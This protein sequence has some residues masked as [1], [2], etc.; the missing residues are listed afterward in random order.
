M[1]PLF[2]VGKVNRVVL[3]TL[4]FYFVFHFV[5]GVVPAHAQAPR[6]VANHAH[7]EDVAEGEEQS[8]NAVR[9]YERDGAVTTAV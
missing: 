9:P 5:S 1:H 3:T 7:A 4:Q 2:N 6:N 8:Q